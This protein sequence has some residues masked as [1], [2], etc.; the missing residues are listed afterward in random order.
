[1]P[2][3]EQIC[4][5]NQQ[6][7]LRSKVTSFVKVAKQNGQEEIEHDDVTE[8]DHNDVVHREE[9]TARTHRIVHDVGP[10]VAD[11]ADKSCEDSVFE[12]VE[13][14]PRHFAVLEI[15]GSFSVV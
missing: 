9:C 13:I 14:G 4:K 10:V 2:S 8:G 12:C 6:L 11:E 7:L 3:L 1:M 5:A 15:E